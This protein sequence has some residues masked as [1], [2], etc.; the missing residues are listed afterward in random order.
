ME[1]AQK[2]L[3]PK[4][5]KE[6]GLKSKDIK[7]TK[8]TLE[9]IIESYTKESG[10]RGLYKKLANVMRNT[11]KHVATEE[12]YQSN[13][14]ATDL[15]NILGAPIFEKDIYQDVKV[16]GVAIGLAWTSVGGDILFIEVG[17]SKGKG[18]LTQTGNLGDVMKES[19]T[20]ALSFL[21]SNAEELDINP[22]IFNHWNIHL[23]VPEGAIPKDGPSAGVTMLSAIYSAITQRNVR[24]FLAMSGE[25]TLR[26]KVLP[27]GGI[28]EK[29][30]AAK[31]AGIRE[32]IL[33]KNNKKDVD[34]IKPEHI[35]DLKFHYVTKMTDV[36]EI[37][38][39]KNKTK[40]PKDLESV[41]KKVDKNQ[42]D[43]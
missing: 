34:E 29:I 25:I 33:C 38:V 21:K 26:G 3:I 20:T 16:P 17:L 12:K 19:V 28:K 18:L 31:R 40:H 5:R 36:L 6:H 24:P 14:K 22:E 2:H 43:Q 15:I 7:L 35:E 42:K 9:T 4:T 32:V 27:V 10:V 39:N 30:L 11:A 23:H 37:A 13:I 41:L 8:K 1:I